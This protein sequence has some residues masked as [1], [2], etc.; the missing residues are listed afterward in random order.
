MLDYQQQWVSTYLKDQIFLL[1]P[2]MLK[3]MSWKHVLHEYFL[4]LECFT[5]VTM[6]VETVKT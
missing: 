2:Q 5:L 6:T 1:S 4:F 3:Y